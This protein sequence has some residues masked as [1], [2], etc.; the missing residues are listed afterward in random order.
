MPRVISG[1]RIARSLVT[2]AGSGDV[3]TRELDF[4]LA[5]D[6]GIQIEAVLGMG[7]FLDTSPAPS[8]TVLVGAIGAQTLHL[9]TGAIEDLPLVA[10]EDADDIDTEIFW[11]QTFSHVVQVPATAGGGGSGLS[12]TPSGLVTFARPI[13]SARNIS[14]SGKTEA[15]GQNGNFGVLIYYRYIVFT[16]AELGLLLARRQ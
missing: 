7:D 1:L 12:V 10:A 14:H 2:P 8:D 6:A 11:A 15:A 4:Q 13:Q 5:A 9:E 3:V 16:N